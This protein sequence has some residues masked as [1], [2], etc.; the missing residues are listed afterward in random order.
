MDG[1]LPVSSPGENLWGLI[2]EWFLARHLGCPNVHRRELFGEV[3]T[4]P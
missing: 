4:T 3:Q 2:F 1:N